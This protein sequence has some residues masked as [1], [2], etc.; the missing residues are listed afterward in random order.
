MKT[1][2]ITSLIQKT[3]YWLFFV[4]VSLCYCNHLMAA[5]FPATEIVVVVNTSKENL[6]LSKQQVRHIYMGGALSRQFKAV[7]LPAGHPLRADFNTK[8]VGL[9]ES[10]MQAYWAQMKFT[11]R[12]QPPI[13]LLSIQAVVEYLQQVKNSVGYLPAGTELPDELTVISFAKKSQ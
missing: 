1:F 2:T 6:V 5:S 12:S 9:T 3:C 11:G 7:N 4:I 10:R 13:E 8:V